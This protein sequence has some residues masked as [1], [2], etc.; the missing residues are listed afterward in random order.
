M[1]SLR[2]PMCGGGSYHPAG[3]P[4][5]PAPRGHADTRR[6]SIYSPHPLAPC[7]MMHVYILC[8]HLMPVYTGTKTNKT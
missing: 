6:G 5:N 4:A 7:I 1:G 3:L 2:V 8:V